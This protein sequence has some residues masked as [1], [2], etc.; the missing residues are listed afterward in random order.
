MRRE[1]VLRS[2]VEFAAVIPILCPVASVFL[3]RVPH[4][5]GRFG[6]RERS[7]NVA[8]HDRVEPLAGCKDVRVVHEAAATGVRSVAALCIR[9]G[10][11][12]GFNVA[13]HGKDRPASLDALENGE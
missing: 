9:E 3:Q 6:N 10:L 13:G 12:I 11:E 5:D 1:G 2:P 4:L 8:V 7:G